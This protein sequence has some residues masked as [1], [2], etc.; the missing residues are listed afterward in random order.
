MRIFIFGCS[1]TSYAWPSWADILIKNA[2]VEGYNFGWGGLGNC[3]IY[4]RLLQADIHYKFTPEDI[5]ITQWTSFDREDRLDAEGN[6]LACGSVFNAYP[7]YD[8]AYIKKYVN[9]T[10]LLTKN[11]TSII[12]ANRMFPNIKNLRIE[13]FFNH[14][15]YNNPGTELWEPFIHKQ[16]KKYNP[17]RIYN[18]YKNDMPTD[19]VKYPQEFSMYGF[20][21]HPDILSH[22][23]FAKSYS[24]D[25]LN[26]P[27]KSNTIEYYN[28]LHNKISKR[29]KSNEAVYEYL[30]NETDF[31]QIRH[32]L[33]D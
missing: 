23:K 22:L 16:D 30:V 4:N 18:F 24:E 7:W 29:M 8:I 17:M 20:D 11:Y 32:N 1:F 19:V 26:I 28:K 14:A 2:D 6:W 12:S 25:V 13:L 10:D 5:V 33:W 31:K 15:L 21:Q 3:G 27:M 9:I